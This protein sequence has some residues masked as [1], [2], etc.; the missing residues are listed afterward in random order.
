MWGE[1]GDKKFGVTVPGSFTV[2]RRSWD[3]VVDRQEQQRALWI[4]V[5]VVTERCGVAL[6]TGG[7][8]AND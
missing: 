2:V 8:C 7:C 3:D 4:M 5:D 1:R 6:K